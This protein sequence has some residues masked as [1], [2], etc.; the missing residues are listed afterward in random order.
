M[1]E[2]TDTQLPKTPRKGSRPNRNPS[3]SEQQNQ[4]QSQSRRG[5]RRGGRGGNQNQNQ[6]QIQ[7]QNQQR[8]APEWEVAP[9]Q[10]PQGDFDENGNFIFADNTPHHGQPSGKK[11]STKKP[12]NTV[13]YNQQ[14]Q[15]EVPMAAIPVQQLPFPTLRGTPHKPY[16]GPTFHASPAASAL[17]MPRF[18]SKSVPNPASSVPSLQER[19]DKEFTQDNVAP[20]QITPEQ[21]PIVPQVHPAAIPQGRT[22]S[23]LD[24]IFS[25]ARAEKAKQQQS[26]PTPAMPTQPPAPKSTKA[27]EKTPSHWA[28]IYGGN[29]PQHQRNYSADSSKGLFMMELDGGSKSKPSPKQETIQG[30]TPV[31]NH[32]HIVP[33]GFNNTPYNQQSPMYST[34]NYGVSTPVLPSEMEGTPA[35]R[36][37]SVPVNHQSR[38]SPAPRSAGST[39]FQTPPPSN[40][41]SQPLHYGNRNL[42]PLFQAAR[43]NSPRNQSQLRREVAPESPTAFTNELPGSLPVQGSMN[44]F[45]NQASTPTNSNAAAQKY[46]T[47]MLSRGPLSGSPVSHNNASTASQPLVRTNNVPSRPTVSNMSLPPLHQQSPGGSMKAR[48]M[49]DDLRRMLKI[50]EN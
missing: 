18:F 47:D 30:S 12:V 7:N 20:T 15:H 21:S 35:G 27:T 1:T 31:V 29:R 42:S 32:H 17:P 3:G 16:A 26:L 19:A 8:Q 24:F 49:E 6:N 11:R 38:P 13:P 33:S 44:G 2:P 37:G 25:A 34:A 50:S 4:G 23:P 14:F 39:P 41:H 48:A 5:G 36:P 46:L 40:V 43:N 10:E 28:S 22:E 45:Y 9:A